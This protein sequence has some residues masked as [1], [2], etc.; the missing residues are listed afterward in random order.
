MKSI[1]ALLTCGAVAAWLGISASPALAQNAV[2]DPSYTWLGYMNVYDLVGGNSAGSYLWGSPWAVAD[3]PAAWVG[4]ELR[5][6]PNVSTWNPGDPYWVNNGQPNKWLEANFYVDMGPAWGGQTVSFSGVSLE[7]SLVAPYT[8]VAFIKEFT[9]GYGWV[10]MTTAA[11]STGAP[12]S[13]SRSIAPGNITQFGFMLQGPNADP[14]TVAALG[15]VRIAMIPEPQVLGL[16]L[17]GILA[18]SLWARRRG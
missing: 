9:S 12:F 2:V 3:L 8:A 1:C 15:Q 7:N 16:L 5:L 11:L 18:V 4:Q 6:S 14:A 17:P 13:V 10:G